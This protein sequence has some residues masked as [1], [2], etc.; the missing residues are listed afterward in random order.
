MFGC[1]IH[2]G[3]YCTEAEKIDGGKLIWLFAVANSYGQD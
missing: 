3:E 1:C 2:T